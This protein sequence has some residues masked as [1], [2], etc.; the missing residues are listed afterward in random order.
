[1]GLWPLS[2]W[3]KNRELGVGGVGPPQSAVLQVEIPCPACD[4][5]HPAPVSSHRPEIPTSDPCNPQDGQELPRRA[6]HLAE[7]HQAAV[8]PVVRRPPMLQAAPVCSSARRTAPQLALLILASVPGQARRFLPPL[9]RT[10]FP[11]QESKTPVSCLFP[12]APWQSHPCLRGPAEWPPPAPVSAPK[13]ALQL[14][15]SLTK[16]ISIVP[17]TLH[18]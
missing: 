6:A 16:E 8:L 12:S 10:A 1:M 11:S 15:V 13:T 17:K 14:V 18:F 5:P 4:L 3:Q 7:S 9:V 2:A